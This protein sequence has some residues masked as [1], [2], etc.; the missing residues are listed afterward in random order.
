MLGNRNEG[1]VECLSR[2]DDFFIRKKK[3][4]KKVPSAKQDLTEPISEEMMCGLRK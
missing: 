1:K 4:Q 2:S 3:K